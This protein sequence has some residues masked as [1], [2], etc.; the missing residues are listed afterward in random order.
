[1]KT[2]DLLHFADVSLTE[3]DKNIEMSDQEF[4]QL[5]SEISETMKKLNRLQKLYRSQTGRDYQPFI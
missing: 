4:S 2:Q 5:K 3:Q 1:M